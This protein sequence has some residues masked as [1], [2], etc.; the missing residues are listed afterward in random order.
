MYTFLHEK[1]NFPNLSNPLK[2]S[3]FLSE[4]LVEILIRDFSQYKNANVET[5]LHP[6]IDTSVIFLSILESKEHLFKA[7]ALC[8][9]KVQGL[10][11]APDH[12][13]N[14]KEFPFIAPALPG[15]HQI[16]KYPLCVY[17]LECI[18]P[19]RTTNIM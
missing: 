1:D 16:Q 15:L 5:T 17:P 13:S 12:G 3:V 6:E 10:P 19:G 14:T 4:W 11:F 9:T 7:A 2:A 8:L 18:T